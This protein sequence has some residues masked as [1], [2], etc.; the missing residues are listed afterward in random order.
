[1]RGVGWCLLPLL[2]SLC[3]AVAA[4]PPV[5]AGSELDYPPFALVTADGR[6]D[7]FAVE[8]LRAVLKAMGREVSFRVGPWNDLKEDL[9]AG[10]LQVLPLVARTAERDR[11]Y[12][13]SVPY[14]SMHG[15][16]VVRRSEKR[17][18]QA[19]DLWDREVLVMKGDIAEE[20]IRA[21]HLTDH[22]FTTRTV[23]ESLRELA[24]GDRDAVVV[25]KLVA[26]KMLRELKLDGLMTIEP[27]LED[28]Q[29]FS[30]AVHE[31]DRE[32][33]A[34]LNE[35]LAL[36]S[37]DGTLERLRQK[38]LGPLLHEP[39]PMPWLPIAGAVLLSLLFAWSVAYLWQ[40]SLAR[41]VKVRTA[42]LVAAHAQ[43]V[44]TQALR[45][46]EA[47]LRQM[48]D[49]LPGLV[50]TTDADGAANFVSPQWV[51]YTGRPFE[52]QLGDGWLDV[53]HP[54]DRSLT[55]ER[56]RAATDG[57]GAYD[58][59]YR[60][61]RYDGEYRWFKVRGTPIRDAAGRITH[62]FGINIDIDD[63]KRAEESLR[64]HTDE[65][66]RMNAELEEFA[67]VASHDLK[68]PLR[69]VANLALVIDEDVSAGLDEE[70]RRRLHLLRRRVTMMDQLI[71]GLLTYARLGR[72]DPQHG[73]PVPLTALLEELVGTLTFPPGFRVELSGPLPTLIADPLQMRQV[74]QNLIVNAVAHHDRA[75]GQVWIR[76]SDEGRVW[77][78]EVADD[79]PGIPAEARQRV[80]RMFATSGKEGHTGIGLAVVRKLVLA[81]GGQIELTDNRP[82]G[83]LFRIRWPK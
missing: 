79:G 61:R 25:Q 21:H 13:F 69:A 33:L 67:Y 76:A 22:L 81:W 17:I 65:L 8:L 58:V 34:V 37:A 62:W 74:F 16:I 18:R 43:L 1:M 39:P 46:S 12:D 26:E 72:A 68:A 56:W 49:F 2:L 31:G 10:R 27:M 38:W 35:G 45:A 47:K 73:T 40:R 75:N 64:R 5:A 29:S 77:C 52:T 71:E 53:V 59:E 60:A 6:A 57:R 3:G 48:I 7:G 78:L 54:E 63:L 23:E 20:Y 44:Q 55:V 66:Q 14:L 30:F 42:E 9:A 36:V 11:V 19:A 15:S 70:N 83:A 50:W 24:R 32:L 51:G 28:Y 80:F 41:M 82:R 4:A